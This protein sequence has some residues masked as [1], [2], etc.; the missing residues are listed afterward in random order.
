MSN[1]HQ[2]SFKVCNKNIGKG[3]VPMDKGS[4]I[5]VVGNSTSN[6]IESLG[7]KILIFKN[8]NY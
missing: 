5:S 8:L 2:P 4:I 3:M 1:Y 6:I 7:Q